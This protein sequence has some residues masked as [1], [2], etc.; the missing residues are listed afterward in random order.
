VLCYINS[1]MLMLF[2]SAEPAVVP[3]VR[4]KETFEHTRTRQML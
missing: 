3:Q 1:V 2:Q 4:E